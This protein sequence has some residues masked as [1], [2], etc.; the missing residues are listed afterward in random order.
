MENARWQ[1][2]AITL[3]YRKLTDNG[4]KNNGLI[5]TGYPV[6]GRQGKMQTSGSCLYSP[7]V[8]IDSSCAWDPRVK[9]LVFYES[10]AVF[11]VT[12]FGDFIRDVKRLTDF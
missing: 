1:V 4:L 5:F 12:K 11:S 6:V 8:R 10:T 7:T 2:T 3:G 9:G